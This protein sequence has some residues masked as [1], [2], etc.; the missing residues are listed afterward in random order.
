MQ[1]VNDGIYIQDI[2]PHDVHVHELSRDC[3]RLQTKAQDHQTKS[4]ARRAG[5]INPQNMHHFVTSTTLYVHDPRMRQ[6][7]YLLR[8]II[9]SL[10]RLLSL[11][12]SLLCMYAMNSFCRQSF[13]SFTVLAAGL[14][15]A[16]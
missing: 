6:I 14:S 13:L 12:C 16:L 8:M 9:L 11:R 5:Q 3:T 4:S 7:L 15:V 2:N 10:K 1:W